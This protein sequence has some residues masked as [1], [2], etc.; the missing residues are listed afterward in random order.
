MKVS[1]EIAK[2]IWIPILVQLRH[3]RTSY[4]YRSALE[5]S[6]GVRRGYKAED[7]LEELQFALNDLEKED[8]VHV[9]KGGAPISRYFGITFENEPFSFTSKF[10]KEIEEANK[11]REKSIARQN[12]W[13]HWLRPT[14]VG[15][16]SGVIGG[17]IAWLITERLLK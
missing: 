7:M 12:A 4:D 15:L 8:M 3:E 2:K 5:V 11:Q 10:D 14:L 1:P 13:E 16:A 9:T 17:V 6:R